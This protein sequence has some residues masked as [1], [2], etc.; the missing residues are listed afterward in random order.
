[1]CVL[2]LDSACSSKCGRDCL[3]SRC[4]R[5]GDDELVRNKGVEKVAESCVIGSTSSR[6]EMAG[7]NVRAAPG[8]RCRSVHLLH[9][10]PHC[11]RDWLV[12]VELYLRFEHLGG[13]Y[14]SGGRLPV[15]Q[16][17]R[18]RR[19]LP[20]SLVSG[21][22]SASLLLLTKCRCWS[23]LRSFSRVTGRGGGGAHLN[24]R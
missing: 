22:P 12:G 3:A 17:Y 18:P 5:T 21:R 6:G 7:E 10:P 19:S 8:T 11:S 20:D 13:A 1:M 4:A 9:R 15:A 2:G 24:D 23:V 14:Q 16:C